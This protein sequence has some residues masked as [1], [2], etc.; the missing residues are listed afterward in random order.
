MIRPKYNLFS[1]EVKSMITGNI[2]KIAGYIA[3]FAGFGAAMLG[4][5]ANEQ[6]MNKTIEEKVNKALAEK[7]KEESETETE[8]E[9]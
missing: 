3:T 4:N 9:S 2:I 6:K 1:E 5:W 8:E 7:D